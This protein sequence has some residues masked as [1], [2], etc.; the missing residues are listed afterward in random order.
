MQPS[1][2]RPAAGLVAETGHVLAIELVGLARFTRDEIPG[3]VTQFQRMVMST[4]Q[5]RDSFNANR[6]LIQR[7]EHTIYLIFLGDPLAGLKCALQAANEARRLPNIRLRMGIHSGTVHVPADLTDE[8]D[9]A[10]EALTGARLLMTSGS[11]GHILV[12]EPVARAASAVELWAGYIHD[13]GVRELRP[14]ASLRLFSVFGSGLGNPGP[15]GRSAPTAI[16]RER[17]VRRRISGSIL[18]L[19]AFLLLASG[20]AASWLYIP[21]V[22]VW[23]EQSYENAFPSPPRKTAN[24]APAPTVLPDPLSTVRRILLTAAARRTLHH[25]LRRRSQSGKVRW[26]PTSTLIPTPPTIRR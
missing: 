4:P 16:V 10:G 2:Q 21:G 22:R 20:A 17:G 13:L 6:L 19:A 1:A 3:I 24:K 23:A 25:P 15:P 12:S 18:V 26:R 9:C 11:E 7:R 5:A 14:G 8:R